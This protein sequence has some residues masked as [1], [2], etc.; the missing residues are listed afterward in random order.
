MISL[1]GR[2]QFRI[3]EVH[4][5]IEL[6]ILWSYMNAGATLKIKNKSKVGKGE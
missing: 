2:H 6:S 4:L 5:S 1:N 3:M